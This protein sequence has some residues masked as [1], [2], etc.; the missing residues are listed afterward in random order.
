MGRNTRKTDQLIALGQQI[1]ASANGSSSSATGVVVPPAPV[2]VP[3]VAP[4]RVAPAVQF[5]SASAPPADIINVIPMD[6]D[7]GNNRSTSSSDSE[8]DNE[9]LEEVM[10]LLAKMAVKK[11][12]SSKKK[13]SAKISRVYSGTGVLPGLVAH[14]ASRRAFDDNASMMSTASM[15]SMQSQLSQTES[16]LK[17]NKKKSKKLAQ[18]VEKKN[19]CGCKAGMPCSF[20]MCRCKL[21]GRPCGKHCGCQ[22]CKDGCFQQFT[23]KAFK[24]KYGKVPKGGLRYKDFKNHPN[25]SSESSSSSSSSDSSDSD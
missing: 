14:R 22:G 9:S 6:I 7:D 8:L 3:A 12:K 5:M 13:K 10:K 17:K 21:A 1:I 25:Y 18:E 23:K 4:A 16:K 11:K 15:A 20:P 19:P 24:K 2:V